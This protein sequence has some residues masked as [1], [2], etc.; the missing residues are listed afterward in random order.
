MQD[1]KIMVLAGLAVVVLGA[2][3]AFA[4]VS[5]NAGTIRDPRAVRSVGQPV[6]ITASDGFL[7][8]TTPRPAVSNAAAQTHRSTVTAGRWTITIPYSLQVEGLSA[9]RV[10]CTVTGQ[11]SDREVIGRSEQTFVLGLPG[12]GRFVMTVPAVAGAETWPAG[13]WVCSARL[14]GTRQTGAAAGVDW[15]ATDST[16]PGG[17]VDVWIKEDGSS[18]WWSGPGFDSPFRLRVSGILR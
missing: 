4:Q 13:G 1:K 12:T 14:T 8:N 3:P 6:A 10:T 11:G 16:Q 5:P 18:R 7:L 15:E 2:G 17:A 9:A